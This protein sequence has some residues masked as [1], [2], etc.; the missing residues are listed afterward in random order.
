MQLL[1]LFGVVSGV[2]NFIRNCRIN[3]GF[4]MFTDKEFIA[5]KIKTFR[6][7][8]GLTQAELAE[9]I[10]ITDKHVCKIE[11]A[12]YMPSLDTFLKIAQV[13]NIGLDEFGIN[14]QPV[15]NETRENFLKLLY[16]TPNN[17]LEVYYNIL[18]EVQRNFKNLKK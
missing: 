12:S 9:K 1:I 8:A 16:T 14:I 15:G 6:K 2:I 11:N 7:Y 18:L 3:I 10:G 4:Y 5:D 17:E 13:L